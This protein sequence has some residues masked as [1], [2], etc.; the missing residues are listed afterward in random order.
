MSAISPRANGQFSL[1]QE[2]RTLRRVYP[3]Y[4]ALAFKFEMTPAPTA[5]LRDLNDNPDPALLEAAI[6]WAAEVDRR[7]APHQL[8]QFL[9]GGTTGNSEE[10][11]SVLLERYLAKDP[12]SEQDRDKVDVLLTQYFHVCA[13]PSYRRRDVRLS[14]VAE[15]LEPLLGEAAPEVPEWLEGFFDDVAAYDDEE[16]ADAEDD[17]TA[18]SGKIQA[19]LTDVSAA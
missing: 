17:A 14:E 13:P 18:R 1:A 10:Q 5:S 11:L 3:I 15:V 9:Q 19:E 2:W 8:R 7:I 6:R 12:K 16:L 4:Q